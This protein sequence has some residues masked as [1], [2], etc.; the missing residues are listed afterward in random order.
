ENA[1]NDTTI[2]F[3]YLV[4]AP[5]DESPRPVGIIP[6]INYHDDATKVTL[7]LWA[8][9]KNSVYARGDF[10]DW[11]VLPE[12]Q[13]KRDGEYFWLEL[14]GLTEGEEYAFQYLINESVWVAD[15]YADKILDP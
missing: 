4:S 11:D 2:T 1:E 8:P 3:K 6:G 10:S 7:C 9:G 5:S 12:N 14:S 15:P 13:M